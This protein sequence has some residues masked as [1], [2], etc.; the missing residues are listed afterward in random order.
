VETKIKPIP[1]RIYPIKCV[2]ISDDNIIS[3][4]P[5][6]AINFPNPIT[7]YLPLRSAIY[8]KITRPRNPPKNKDDFNSVV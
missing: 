2:I 8:E 4:D 1:V 6:I 7:N 3:S 5:A